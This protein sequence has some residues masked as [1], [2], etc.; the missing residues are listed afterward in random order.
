MPALV[1]GRLDL[2]AKTL[3][4]ELVRWIDGLNSRAS[5]P[6]V[7]VVV[8]G[9]NDMRALKGLGVKANFILADHLLRETKNEGYERVNGRTFI[10]MTDFDRE[11]TSLYRRLRRIIT[12]LGGKVDDYPRRQYASLGLPLLIEEIESFVR[13]RF[14]DWDL[15]RRN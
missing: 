1:D 13:R 6:G 12:E 15:L 5:V 3:I 7:E 4:H 11:G 8:E 2:R 10:I 14:E 9:P